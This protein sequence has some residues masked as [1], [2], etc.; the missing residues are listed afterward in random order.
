MKIDVSRFAGRFRQETRDNLVALDTAIGKL[1]SAI[2][3]GDG[4][5]EILREMMRVAHAIKGAARMLG[6]A[7]VNNLCHS[8]EELLIGLRAK[9]SVESWEVDRI[10]EARKGIDRLLIMSHEATDASGQPLDWLTV[11][12]A[13]LQHGATGAPPQ[14]PT[15]QMAIK[16]T[17]P[18]APVA[19]A[20]PPKTESWRQTTVRVDI[21]SIDD[22]LYYGRELTQ[23]LD[24][25]RRAHGSVD[26]LRNDLAESLEA[27]MVTSERF[28][29]IDRAFTGGILQRLTA[30]SLNLRERIAEVDRNV[31]QIDSGA[32][33]LRMRPISELFETI[34]LQARELAKSLGKQIQVE[35]SGDTVRLDGRIVELLR[36]P[37]LHI[38]RNALDHG[39]ES[40]EERQAEGKPSVGKLSVGAFENAGWARI[41]VADDG[42]GINLDTLWERARELGLTDENPDLSDLKSGYRFLFDDRFTSRKG[43]TNISGRGVGLAA[44]KRRMQE[45]RG[46]VNVESVV[47]MGARWTLSM[48]T[49]LSS[50]RTL[51]VAV[52]TPDGMAYLAFPTAMVQETS[53]SDNRLDG[54][55]DGESAGGVEASRAFSL[56]ELLMGRLVPPRPQE[57]YLVHCSDGQQSAVFGVEQILAESEVVIEPLPRI[58]RGIGLIAGAAPLTSDDITLVLN[59][60]SL[61][62]FA[63]SREREEVMP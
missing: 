6:F 39:I 53:R 50:Q 32:V 21:D 51:V 9:G 12:I 19:P 2:L 30:V 36:E 60:P 24:G 37:I 49:S 20:P 43:A 47:K 31:R 11:L 57:L 38:I 15:P 41:V 27:A 22:L 48:P 58:A 8:L 5:D 40:Q 33:E 1:D 26:R 52:G 29:K 46:D 45:L 55:A 28:V 44:V 61:L 54:L 23:A 56:S 59:V 25:L 63:L 18:R 16:E 4:N 7:G 42:R 34:P 3:S 13:S 14:K 17:S 62:T 10:V 35:F